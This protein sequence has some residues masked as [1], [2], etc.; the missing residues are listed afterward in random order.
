MEGTG[1]DFMRGRNAPWITL[2]KFCARTVADL[3]VFLGHVDFTLEAEG[4]L[5]VMDGAILVLFAVAGVQVSSLRTLA[6]ILSCSMTIS[7]PNNYVRSAD[8]A[9]QRRAAP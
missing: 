9:A 2:V 3:H 5:R 8:E 4:A 7:Q 1:F 6:C